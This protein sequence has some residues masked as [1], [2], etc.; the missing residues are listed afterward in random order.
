MIEKVKYNKTFGIFLIVTSTFIIGVS[1]LTGL[2]LNTITG[3]IL[4][5]MGI[6]YLNAPAI[7]Y[8]EN[9]LMLKN[10]YGRTLKTY[11]FNTDKITV[12]D[13]TMYANDRKIRIGSMMLNKAELSKLHD[14]ISE[15]SI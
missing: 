2:S 1:F 10:L 8:T 11:S 7:E 12:K 4:L 15:K 14:F 9:E 5:L 3:G 13:G 6:L